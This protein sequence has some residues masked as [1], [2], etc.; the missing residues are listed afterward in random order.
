MSRCILIG[1]TGL[2]PL[3]VDNSMP[4]DTPPANCAYVMMTGAEYA[5]LFNNDAG[6]ATREEA[7]LILGAVLMLFAV[8]FAY[9]MLVKLLSA[10]DTGSDEKH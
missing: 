9:R 1:S 5:M 8:V 2:S 4:A 7:D 10:G 6:I 3:Y